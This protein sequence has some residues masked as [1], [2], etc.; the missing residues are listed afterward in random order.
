MMLTGDR[1]LASDMQTWLGLCP[2]AK[3]SK[4]AS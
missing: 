1:Q 4:P 2:F 3:V